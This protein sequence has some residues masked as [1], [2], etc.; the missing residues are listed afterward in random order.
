MEGLRN[1]MKA[2]NIEYKKASD[3]PKSL[4]MLFG[5]SVF[6]L[7]G[8]YIPILVERTKY[9]KIIEEALQ[10]DK[11]IGVLQ[12]NSE[13]E[14]PYDIGCIARITSFSEEGNGKA[15]IALEGVCRFR[16]EQKINNNELYDVYKISPIS[17]DFKEV[18]LDKDSTPFINSYFKADEVNGDMPD[19]KVRKE[20]KTLPFDVLI[21]SL[22]IH[23]HFSPQEQQLLL[24]SKN[25]E[26]RAELFLAL[27]ERATMKHQNKKNEMLH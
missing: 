15:V 18:K 5:T 17:E 4:P 7:P 21:N 27:S 19:E 11:L 24:E 14:E 3:L 2:G 9:V 25:I 10:N 16:H 26:T 12:I 13:T 22:C 8:T 1:I 6:I 23:S 20:L